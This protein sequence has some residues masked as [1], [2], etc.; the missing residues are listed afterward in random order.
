MSEIQDDLVR[1][2]EERIRELEDSL[3]RLTRLE[4]EL[5][6]ARDAWQITFDALLDPV[7]VLS[8][9]GTIL[10]ANRAM[11]A[12]LGQEAA[13]LVGLKC[14]RLVH[15]TEHHIAGCPLAASLRTGQRESMEMEVDG[16]SLFVVTDPIRGP[17]G[18]ID[19]FIHV[20][21]DITQHKGAM[22]S[23]ADNLVLLGIASE[24]VRFGGWSVDLGSRRC[25]WSDAV[26]DIHEV[27][28]GFSPSVEEGIGFYAPEG[29]VRIAEVFQAC[30]ERGVPYDEELEIVTARGR[31]VWVRTSGRAVRDASGRIARVQ[32]AFQDI[33]DRRRAEEALRESEERLRLT[34]QATH[35][36]I[37]DWDLPTGRAVFSPSYYAMLGH[38]PDEF[39]ASYESWR[40]RLHP[41]DRARVERDIG[42][43]VESR[44]GFAVEF[45]MRTR[46]GGWRWILGR[47]MVVEQDA[48]GRPV[49]MVGTHADLTERKQAE[50]REAQ[51]K[52]QLSQAQRLESIGRLAGGVAHDFNNLLSVILSF[53]GFTREALHAG[54]PVR[55]D[56]EQIQRAAERAAH[57]TR[58]LL[59]FGRRQVLA[60]EVLDLDEVLGRTE[61]MLRRLLGERIEIEVRC[62]GPRARVLADP[63]QIEQLLMNLAVNARDAMPGGG[64]LRLS[65]DSVELTEAEACP[66][67]LAAGQYVRLAV[68]DSGCGMD[69]DTLAHVFE[70]FFTTK[71]EGQGTGLGLSMV[72][73]IVKQ[74]RGA[75]AVDSRP[76]QGSTFTVYLPPAVGAPAEARA[77]P[78]PV[79]AASGEAVLVVED[80]DAVRGIA[81]RI[82]KNAGYRVHAAA[83]AGEA[84]LVCEQLGGEVDLLLTD[85][86]MPRVGGAEL[87]ARLATL[88]PRLRVLFMSGYPDDAI[89]QDGVLAPGTPFI[90]KPFTAAALTRKVREALEAEARFPAAAAV[91]DHSP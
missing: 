44:S 16:R 24:T 75:I 66:L 27:P 10:K 17:G 38:A 42:R 14:F 54:D 64:Q 83:N 48:A 8:V 18:E 6:E 72:Y 70:P 71:D 23:L 49:R 13:S 88:C 47:G 57:L 77:V 58:Q 80:E 34:L 56:I 81:V 61:S 3:V 33:S 46:S 60:P 73:G 21:R 74:S 7:A 40:E 32:G 9:D 67:G 11:G 29:R 41:E 91:R 26:A 2:L 79:P 59:A 31:R 15:G 82:L 63:G 86:V 55:D 52:E 45:R 30:A 35:D 37:W 68:R 22:R 51:L 36:G 78:A 28:R 1:R 50:A 43:A 39:P 20:I 19:G 76:G 89:A 62:A 87:A 69:A 53:A 25:S 84:L 90:A 5:R 12:H 65:T 85:V 4:S